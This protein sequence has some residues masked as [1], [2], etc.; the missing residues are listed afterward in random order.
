MKR[1]VLCLSNAQIEQLFRK[2]MVQRAKTDSSWQVSVYLNVYSMIGL[3]NFAGTHPRN[4][5]K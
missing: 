1:E 2:K 5:L 3:K 4:P